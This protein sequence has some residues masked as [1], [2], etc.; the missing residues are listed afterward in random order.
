MEQTTQNRQKGARVARRVSEHRQRGQ[1]IRARV[2]SAEK[3]EV[4]AQAER[5]G[6]TEGEYVRSRCL[7]APQTRA[8]RRPSADM[9]A[10]AQLV[11]QLG[12]VGSNINQLAHVANVEGRLPH[13]EALKRELA[14]LRQVQAAVMAAMGRTPKGGRSAQ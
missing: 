5:A 13:G 4:A 2:N 12:K 11:G 9:K 3:Q 8:A 1:F 6:M 14:Q 7:D 10:L